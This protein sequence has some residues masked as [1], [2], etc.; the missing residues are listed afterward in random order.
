MDGDPLHLADGLEQALDA[1]DQTDVSRR[2]VP[3]ELLEPADEGRLLRMALEEWGMILVL[4]VAAALAPAWVYPLPLLLLAGRYHALGV[5]L[6]D[7]THMPLR[8]KSARV[9][10]VELLCGYPIASTVEAMRYH[11]LRHHRDSGMET[12]PYYKAGRQ[13]ARW[14]IRNV[15]RGLL[16]VPFWAL[17]APVGAVAAHVR[18]LR[19]PYARIFLQDR[20][21]TDR[22]DVTEV[23]ACARADRGQ[24]VFFVALGAVAVLA[25]GPVV[26]G[27]AVPVSLAGLLSARRLLLEHRYERVSD[28]RP[29]TILRTTADNHVDWLGK[30]VLAP[31]N[32]GCHVVHH[33]HPRAGLHVLPPLRA[34][35]RE[36]YPDLYPAAR[37]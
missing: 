28:R 18:P 7:V 20:S 14:W 33:L 8:G 4:W 9:W 19:N 17:R 26:W 13:G 32:I 12:D 36:R 15:A 34:W 6:H 27:Y 1:A 5:I 16:L 2:A 31:R 22:R 11:H 10:A 25:P 30:L 35:Y 37:N 23:L 24:L 21:G 3:A 29:E